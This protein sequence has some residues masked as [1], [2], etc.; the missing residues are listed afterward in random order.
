MVMGHEVG[1]IANCLWGRPD[2]GLIGGAAPSP[3]GLNK[4]F[5]YASSSGCGSCTN[6]VAVAA[7]K[8]GVGSCKAQEWFGHWWH[9]L[10]REEFP[11]VERKERGRVLGVTLLQ[12]FSHGMYRARR[13]TSFADKN[14]CWLALLVWLGCFYVDLHWIVIQCDI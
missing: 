1:C 12:K 13:S 6:S 4:R 11:I 3:E 9:V 8:G 5:W 7:V 14:N 10:S 2:V